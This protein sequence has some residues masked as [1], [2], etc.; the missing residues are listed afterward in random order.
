MTILQKKSSILNPRLASYRSG[1][2]EGSDK[3]AWLTG[4]GV[5]RTYNAP[6]NFGNGKQT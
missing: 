2:S 5:D 4:S 3:S 6:V 1:A